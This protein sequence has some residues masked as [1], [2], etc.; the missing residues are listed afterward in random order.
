MG[1]SEEYVFGPYSHSLDPDLTDFKVNILINNKGQACLA[2]FASLNLL[3]AL[4]DQTGTSSASQGG[5]VRW[6]SPELLAPDQFYS[7]GSRPTEKSDC[8]ALG[9]VIYEV[10]AGEAPFSHW[11][12]LTVL[13]KVLEG[14]RPVRLQGFPDHIWEMLESCWRHKPNDRPSLDAVLR[15]LRD[16][17]QQWTLSR[18]SPTLDEDMETDSDNQSHAS[19]RFFGMFSPSRP[20]F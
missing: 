14:E 15:C 2:D 20:K 13:W 1:I 9:M 6:M 10:L 5:F 3:V 7:T 16:V 19:V 4:S 17:E 18:I 12:E 11:K 8:Y